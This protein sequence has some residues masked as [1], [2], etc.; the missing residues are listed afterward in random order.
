MELWHDGRCVARHER[1]YRGQQQ[2]LD[3]E[4]YLDV[5]HIRVFY[6]RIRHTYNQSLAP[7]V[8]AH[9]LV[10]EITHILQSVCRHSD[11]GVMKARWEAGD[12][13]K[14]SR[15]PL[16][17]TNEDVDLI[18]SGLATRGSRTLVAIDTVGAAAAQ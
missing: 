13:L 18:Y 17:F 2:I 1:C 14:M 9:V 7:I 8:L 6:D 11:Q 16:Q 15:K 12:Y 3:L 4:H 10:H 5:L